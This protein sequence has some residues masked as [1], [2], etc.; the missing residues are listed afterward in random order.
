M[1]NFNNNVETRIQSTLIHIQFMPRA[2]NKLMKEQDLVIPEQLRV[3]VDKKINDTCNY[4]CR[5]GS[6]ASN[7]MIT[8]GEQVSMMPKK[9]NNL[10]AITQKHFWRECQ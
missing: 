8:Q 10:A 2:T 3:L 9:N 5:Q 7:G 1:H 4:M 6:M